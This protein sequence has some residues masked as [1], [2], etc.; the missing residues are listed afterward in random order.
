MTKPDYTD[1]RWQ[2]KRLEILQR[3]NFTCTACDAQTKT[4]HVHHLYYCTGRKPWEYPNFALRSL[5]ETCHAESADECRGDKGAY[6]LTQWEQVL[7]W[8]VENNPPYV[9]FD[10]A[11]DLAA[12]VAR[13]AIVTKTSV[14]DVIGGILSELHCQEYA[15]V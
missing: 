4:L 14:H 7:E 10:E 12:S 9:A 11:W 1:P 13:T 15:V 8:L 6:C 2:R 5:C 3:D